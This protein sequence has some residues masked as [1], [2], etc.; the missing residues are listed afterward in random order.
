MRMT[1][2]L[3]DRT[4]ARKPFWFHALLLVC[5][6]LNLCID[7]NLP[8]VRSPLMM[9]TGHYFDITPLLAF[10]FNEPVY[11]LKN[12]P[13]FPSESQESRGLWLGPAC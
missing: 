7:P 12:D 5:M 4:G 9:I 6:C 10:R 2:R 13:S 8:G 11:F 1:D 3:I